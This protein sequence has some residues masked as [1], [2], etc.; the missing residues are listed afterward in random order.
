MLHSLK[1]QKGKDRHEY[2]MTQS[3][4]SSSLK[5]SLFNIKNVSVELNKK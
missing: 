2:I 5:K 1:G 4:A 3:L